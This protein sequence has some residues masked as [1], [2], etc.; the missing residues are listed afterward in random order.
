MYKIST[1]SCLALVSFCLIC[2]ASAV[3][4][5]N[6]GVHLQNGDTYCPLQGK[7]F[8]SENDL[9]P[10]KYRNRTPG[11]PCNRYGCGRGCGRGYACRPRN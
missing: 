10:R 7:A 6:R 1:F 11:K 4:S 3:P 9:G 2:T 5:E 8:S